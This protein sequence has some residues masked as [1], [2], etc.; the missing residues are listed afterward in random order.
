VLSAPKIAVIGG[1]GVVGE[2][3]AREISAQIPNSLVT[4]VSRTA[5]TSASAERVIHKALDVSNSDALRSLLADMD[6]AIVTT[7]PFE[8][9]GASIHQACIDARVDVVDINDSASA[10]AAIM[11]T[12]ASAR[13]KGVRILTGMG[14]APGLSTLLLCRLAARVGFKPEHYRARLYMGARN[15]GGPS[16]ASVL[17]SGFKRRLPAIAEGR[18]CISAAQ[19]TGPDARYRFPGDERPLRLLPFASPEVVTLPDTGQARRLSVQSLDWRYHVQFLPPALGRMLALSGLTASHRVITAFSRS[20][21]RSGVRM[22][23]RKD[24]DDTTTLVVALADGS[25]GLAIHGPVATSHLTAM[26]AVGA[27]LHLLGPGRELVPG[28]YPFERVLAEDPGVEQTIDAW[29]ARRGIIIVKQSALSDSTHRAVFGD[30]ATFDGTAASLRNYGK[31]WYTAGPIPPRVKRYQQACLRNSALWRAVCDRTSWAAR[32]KIFMRMHRRH[33]RLRRLAE[34]QDFSLRG[35]ASIRA[36][37]IKDFS[38]FAAGFGEARDLLGDDAL[39]LYSEMFLD[40]GAMEMAWLWP[41]AHVFARADDP[42]RTLIEYIGAYFEA[43]TALG[44]MVA[45]FRRR[46][47]G[48]EVEVERCRYAEILAALGCSELGGLVREMEV[49]AIR[50]IASACH[51]Q[52]TW[53]KATAGGSG[54]L[55]VEP[56]QAASVASPPMSEVAG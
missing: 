23:Q 21:H 4:A 13:A 10:A 44:V 56:L 53:T 14:L 25:N 52:T 19:W 26:T 48:F 51:L 36:E 33:V 12:D 41:S 43:S 45:S 18:G 42:V 37:I 5:S 3:V 47:H 20:F 49:Q 54:T 30:S 7:G 32:A 24:A 34:R 2:I 35:E 16:N 15:S 46:P 29:L 38:L 28:V 27:M 1:T 40:S 8:Q 22:R 39:H 9:F 11:E 55:V 17:L 6:V 31:C 50:H